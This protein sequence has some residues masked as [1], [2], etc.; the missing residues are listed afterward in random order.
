[1]TD[2][3][4]EALEE[5][6]RWFDDNYRGT[7]L[8]E[9]VLAALAAPPSEEATIDRVLAAFDMWTGKDGVTLRDAII[10]APPSKEATGLRTALHE[11]V[12]RALT[13]SA[14]PVG[15]RERVHAAIDAALDAAPPSEDATGLDARALAR[16]LGKCPQVSPVS[17]WV[18]CIAAEYARL[19]A[20][21]GGRE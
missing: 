6:E 7:P 19:T 12:E 2:P 15:R 21:D 3:L 8:H 5:C 4:R 13:L 17:V 16:S 18:D 10:A 1:M 9:M 11:G 14:D 20:S